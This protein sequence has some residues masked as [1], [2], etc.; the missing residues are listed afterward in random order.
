MILPVGH[1]QI[2][3]AYHT[4]PMQL[5]FAILTFNVFHLISIKYVSLNIPVRSL[6]DFTN[7]IQNKYYFLC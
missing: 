2:Q 1:D 6:V 5:D 4:N 7:A 3:N